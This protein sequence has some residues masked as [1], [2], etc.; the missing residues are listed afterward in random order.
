MGNDPRID[1]EHV[2][3]NG[4]PMNIFITKKLWGFASEPPFLH[5]GCMTLIG[6]AI[7]CHGGDAQASREAFDALPPVDRASVVE[8]LK[9]LQVLPLG[10]RSLVVQ[11]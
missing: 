5:N 4:V 11:E 9:T 8:F 10:T 2:M 1:N 6:D 3:Q 7:D